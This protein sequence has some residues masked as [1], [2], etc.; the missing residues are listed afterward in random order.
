MEIT[1][2]RKPIFTIDVP[3][4]GK[5][6][7]RTCSLRE[8]KQLRTLRGLRNILENIA[9]NDIPQT[10][11]TAEIIWAEKYL[12]A[13]DDFIHDYRDFLEL[14][15]DGKEK[16]QEICRLKILTM[17]EKIAADYTGLDFNEI[18][19]LDIIDFKLITAD[20]YKYMIMQ[21]KPDAVK[22]LNGCY[23][24]MHDLFTAEQNFS[25]DSITII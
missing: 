3:T 13:V 8:Y 4:I 1:A 14:P 10:L 20:A 7:C 18:L 24:Y 5:I 23:A 25:A 12:K 6:S 15:T 22:Y 9:V 19:D 2:I 11:K 17:P 16:E 21:N